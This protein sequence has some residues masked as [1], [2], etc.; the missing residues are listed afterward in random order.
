MGLKHILGSFLKSKS[1]LPSQDEKLPF[2]SFQESQVIPLNQPVI[3]HREAS[4]TSLK[5][6]G[7]VDTSTWAILQLPTTLS[8][9][10]P[11]QSPS[12]RRRRMTE[13][14]MQRLNLQYAELV[15]L[16]QNLPQ[17]KRKYQP[18][19]TTVPSTAAAWRQSDSNF[20]ISTTSTSSTVSEDT[21][22]DSAL[23]RLVKRR[24]E[25]TS[26]HMRSSIMSLSDARR[27][28]LQVICEDTLSGMNLS[29]VSMTTSEGGG[30][31][32]SRRAGSSVLTGRR[33]GSRNKLQYWGNAKRYSEGYIG[34]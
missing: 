25:Q 12:T 27:S 10:A 29:A 14:Q 28:S 7:A 18:L 13:G 8:T 6:L 30:R 17:R 33:S 19:S 23:I 16:Y 11:P 32:S 15:L 3:E 4:N 22:K 26:E 20:K 34:L 24:S 2:S 31:R 21:K 5:T 9:F 1:K